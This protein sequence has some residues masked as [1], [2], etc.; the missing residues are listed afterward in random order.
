MLGLAACHLLSS[1]V[2]LRSRPLRKLHYSDRWPR[3]CIVIERRWRCDGGC[4]MPPQI[5][6]AIEP[7]D[8]S[9]SYQRCWL[10]WPVSH[11]LYH[12]CRQCAGADFG[13][14]IL[15]LIQMPR[16]GAPYSTW[17]VPWN[18]NSLSELR[19][20]SHK[21][22]FFSR[23]FFFA[24]SHFWNCFDVNLIYYLKFRIDDVIGVIGAR[25]N[26]SIVFDYGVSRS[27]LQLRGFV[28]FVTHS[29][30]T[31]ARQSAHII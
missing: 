24:F 11:L 23:V 20:A 30:H 29:R 18:L 28:H 7:I 15:I 21:L 10:Q 4:P 1:L 31:C 25:P 27:T 14:G 2:R 6:D 16:G 19:H 17:Q 9:W 5:A 8:D 3:R 13:R 22:G 26:D 12:N